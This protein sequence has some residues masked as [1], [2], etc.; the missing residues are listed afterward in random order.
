MRRPTIFPLFTLFVFFFSSII[1]CSNDAASQ[2]T[3]S[4]RIGEAVN[5]STGKV[6]KV[7][8]EGDMVFRYMPPQSPHGWRYNPMNGQ[9]EYQAQVGTNENY[10]LLSAAR[11]GAFKTKPDLS[12]LTS[13]DINGWTEDEFDIGPGRILLVRGYTD[14]KH[15]LV[16]ITK[17]TA[18]SNDPKT[19]VISFTYEPVHLKHGTPGSAGNNI[20][21]P[22]ILSFRERLHSEK[23]INLDLSNGNVFEL[24]DGY[25]VSRA[26]NGEYVYVDPALRI[27][28]AD[29]S[30][31]QTGVFSAPSTEDVGRGPTETAIS[32][33]GKY[34]AI[35]V[36][37]RLTYTSGGISVPGLPLDAIAIV[38]RN[39]RELA[40]FISA[41]HAAWTPDGR[42]VMADPDKPGLFIADASFKNIQSFPG[43]PNGRIDG[44]SIHPDGKSIAFALNY[45]I[46]IINTDGSGLKQVTQSGLSEVTPAWSPDGK[47]LAFQQSFKNN[48]DFYQVLIVRMSDNK[49]LYVTD[50]KGANREP[51]GRISWIFP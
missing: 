25:G 42:L 46:W 24:F 50:S 2:K 6:T 3:V 4:L 34:I 36:K 40:S 49:V 12:K 14:D 7:K 39:G 8:A 44:I 1:A 35:G 17:L 22:G 10:P 13:G 16:R 37:R 29:K 9:I 38:D 5:F 31:K 33:D 30:G 15:W 45:R 41:T 47:Y 19:W 43:I 51:A 21:V 32:P 26:R 18:T 11:S 27:V 20:Q 23:I 48:K 28:I